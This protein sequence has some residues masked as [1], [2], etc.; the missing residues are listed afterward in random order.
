MKN[1]SWL[2]EQSIPYTTLTFYSNW[3]KMCEDFVQ[4]FDN[5]RTG[6]CIMIAHHFTLMTVVPHPP[7][8]S[9]F[10]RLKI[11]LKGRHFD[12][13]EMIEAVLNTLTEHDFQDAFKHGKST[14]NG[15]YSWNGTTSMVTVV[16]RPK[17]SF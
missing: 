3:V 8:F 7:N 10:P 4:N 11:K 6:C 17:V 9:L 5:K 2:A 14:G 13:I 16:G 12:I 1:L 15:A